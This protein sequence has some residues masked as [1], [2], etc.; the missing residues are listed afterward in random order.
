MKDLSLEQRR[1]FINLVQ[2][3]ESYRHTKSAKLSLPAQFALSWLNAL[4][5]IKW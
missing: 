3:Y 1:V 4:E 2:V 5:K